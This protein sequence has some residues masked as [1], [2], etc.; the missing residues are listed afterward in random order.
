[1]DQ[2]IIGIARIEDASLVEYPLHEGDIRLRFNTSFPVVMTP[3]HYPDGYVAVYATSPPDTNRWQTRNEIDPVVVDGA[4]R[5]QWQVDNLPITLSDKIVEVCSN[6]DVI[7]NGLRDASV[8]TISAAEMASWPIKRTEVLAFQAHG[9]ISDAPSLIIEAQDR[10]I[11][12]DV[13]VGKILAKATER[14]TLEAQI[15]G[16]CGALQD[17][18]RAVKDDNELLAID[19]R[20]GWPREI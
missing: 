5:Q 19:I 13:L 2:T 17:A 11:E 6:I 3:E 15:A 12:L 16:R 7:A 20:S 14:A 4:W 10:G 9:N 18:A 8:A 1:M